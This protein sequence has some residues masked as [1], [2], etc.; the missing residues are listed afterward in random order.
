LSHFS[1]PLCGKNSSI[2]KYDPDNL[3]LDLKTVSYSS[4]GRGGIHQDEKSSILGHKDPIEVE[5]AERTLKIMKMFLDSG[6]LTL[7]KILVELDVVTV[8]HVKPVIR[9][10]PVFMGQAE[11]NE[12]DKLR[13]EKAEEEDILLSLQ[14]LHKFLDSEFYLSDDFELHLHIHKI[15][16][17]NRLSLLLNFTKRRDWKMILKRLSSLD[18]KVTLYLELLALMPAEK[19]I[20]KRFSEGELLDPYKK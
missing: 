11:R 6:S 7:D 12:L 4:G 3:E 19:S 9:E 18:D 14:E 5:L 8:D 10:V 20:H 1:C 17:D 2:A 13:K 15:P 16:K